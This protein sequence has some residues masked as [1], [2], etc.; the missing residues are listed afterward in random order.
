MSL[1]SFELVIIPIAAGLIAQ[2]IKLLTDGIKGN[3]DL[4]HL[5]ASY[6]GMPSSH[7]AFVV[8]L[9]AIVGI[10]EGIDSVSFAITAIFGLLIMRDAL[11]LR[12]HIGHQGKA[13]NEVIRRFHPDATDAIPP[14]EERI[15]HTPAQ[16]LVGGLL[17][18]AIAIGIHYLL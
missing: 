18:F 11:G 7:S 17:G 3:F 2:A 9:A 13:L 4:A 14:L 10:R 12:M 15:G 6:G 1:E 16:L 8:S 5:W